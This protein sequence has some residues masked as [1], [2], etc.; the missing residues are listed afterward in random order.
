MMQ[1]HFISKATTQRKRMLIKPITLSDCH[2][3]G[4]IAEQANLTSWSSDKIENSLNAGVM[5]WAYWENNQILGFILLQVVSI[6]SEILSIAVDQEMRQKGIAKKLIQ[7]YIDSI[8]VGHKIFLE[9]RKTNMPA[10][11]LYEKCGFKKIGE[12][13]NYYQ[14]PTEDAILFQLEK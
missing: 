5:G 14:S 1:S 10:I 6:E 3:C 7:H 12:R 8:E 13:P 2:Q 11:K 9:V 4:L